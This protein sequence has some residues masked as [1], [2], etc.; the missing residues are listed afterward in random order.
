MTPG[1]KVTLGDE[2]IKKQESVIP[3]KK[4]GIPEDIAYAIMFLASDE[5]SYITGQSI[6]VDGGQILPESALDL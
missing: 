5:A 6:I 3:L 2:Y 1:M 4:L